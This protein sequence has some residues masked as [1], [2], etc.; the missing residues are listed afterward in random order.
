MATRQRLPG[1]LTGRKQFVVSE[2]L[3]SFSYNRRTKVL[4]IVFA[5][6]GARYRYSDVPES[7]FIDLSDSEGDYGG[8][9]NKRIRGRYPYVAD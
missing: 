2:A 6:N 4:T 5:R 3:A 9:F 1:G 8:F 7:T